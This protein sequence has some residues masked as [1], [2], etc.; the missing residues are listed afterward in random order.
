MPTPSSKTGARLFSRGVTPRYEDSCQ[1]S[2]AS[3]GIE[4]SVRCGGEA[5]GSVGKK[6]AKA[7][8]LG[9]GVVVDRGYV[10]GLY[11]AG[12]IGEGAAEPQ[13]AFGI[14]SA[15]HRVDRPDR[16][17]ASRRART[18]ATAPEHDDDATCD[19]RIGSRQ[20]QW[21]DPVKL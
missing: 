10:T 19:C 20:R 13:L 5:S 7:R 4:T 17:R 8:G 3:R 1:P 15:G 6:S 2:G 18:Y 9:R 14:G 16:P 12:H 11:A 21:N